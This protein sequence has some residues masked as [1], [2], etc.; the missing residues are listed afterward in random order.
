ME[1]RL[2]T[3]RILFPAE[4]TSAYI[5]IQAFLKSQGVEGSEWMEQM[6]L[7]AAVLAVINAAIYIKVYKITNFAIIGIVTTGFFIWVL[8]VDTVRYE[9][10]W[11]IG[12]YVEYFAAIALIFYTLLS[13]FVPLPQRAEGKPGGAK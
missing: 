9:D 2:E 8:N 1:K 13:P 6:L 5:A 7:I 4:V 11:L 12:Q 3:L 10:L